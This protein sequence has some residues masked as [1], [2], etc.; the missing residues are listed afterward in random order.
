MVLYTICAVL[1]FAV[2]VFLTACY[3]GRNLKLLRKQQE[4]EEELRI[5]FVEPPD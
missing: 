2:G 5:G 4:F 3:I 1:G